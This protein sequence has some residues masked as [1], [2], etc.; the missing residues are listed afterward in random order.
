MS[1]YYNKSAIV[2]KNCKYTTLQSRCIAINMNNEL[3]PCSYCVLKS[4]CTDDC[5]KF[6][7]FYDITN[8]SYNEKYPSIRSSEKNLECIQLID[9]NKDETPY[10]NSN[11]FLYP[12]SPKI[13]LNTLK[14]EEEEKYIYY[15]YEVD[16]LLSNPYKHPKSVWVGD[17]IK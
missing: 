9:F 3:C 15:L 1:V 5:D 7:E 10:I 11:I 16:Y 6:H 4:I 8:K 17:I 14:K 2:C 12:K 13:K